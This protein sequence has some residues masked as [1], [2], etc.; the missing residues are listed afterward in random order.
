M[1]HYITQP[2]DY[3]M[4]NNAISITLNAR[5]NPNRIQGSVASGAA[6]LCYIEGVDGLGYDNGHR[7]KTWPLSLSPTYFNS[8]SEK[9]VYVAIPRSVSVGTLAIVVF[10]SEQLDIYGKNAQ[11]VQVGSTDYYYIWLQGVVSSSGVEGTTNR[12]LTGLNFGMKGTDEDLYDNTS[13][14]WYE[15][16]RSGGGLVT[17]LKPILMRAGSYFR[18]LILGDKELTGV[19]TEA[20]SDSYVNSETLVVTPSYLNGKLLSRVNDDTAQGVITFVKGIIA[21]ITSYFRGISNTGTLENNGDVSVT[22]SVTAQ[23]VVTPKVSA[24]LDSDAVVVEDALNSHGISNTGTLENTGNVSVTG[25]VTAQEVVTPRISAPAGSN[26]VVVEDPINATGGNGEDGIGMEVSKSGIVGKLLR[27]GEMLMTRCLQSF[28]FNGGENIDGTGWQ[29]TD[30]DGSGM[31]RLIVDKLVVRAKAIFN[32]LEVRKLVGI[33]GNYV[34]SPAAGIIEEVDYIKLTEVEAQGGIT[35]YEEELLGYEYVRVPW[36]IRLLPLSIQGS[37]LSRLKRVRSTMTEELWAQVSVFRCWLRADDGTTQTIN[38]WREGMLARCQ[39]MD[40]GSGDGTST[41]TFYNDAT[42]YTAAENKYY[43]RKV[44]KI[45]DGQTMPL[46]DG[47]LHHYID[48]SNIP[49]EYNLGSDRPSAGDSIACFGDCMH[50]D[51]SNIVMIETVG[52]DAPAIKELV[53]V[54]YVGDGTIDWSLDGKTKT[55]ISPVAGNRFVSREYVIETEV[56][57]STV[58]EELYNYHYRGNAKEFSLDVIV[59]YSGSLND[60]ELI[61][62]GSTTATRNRYRVCT[63]AGED[64]SSPATWQQRIAQIG[65]GYVCDADGHLYVAGNGGWE[66]RGIYDESKSAYLSGT[67]KQAIIGDVNTAFAESMGYTSGNFTTNMGAFVQSSTQAI[68]SITAHVESLTA[69]NIL[70]TSTD[71]N[72]DGSRGV[73]G[74]DVYYEAGGYA[75]GGAQGGTP[76]TADAK[77]T[78][79]FW[80]TSKPSG[81]S[82]S[83]KWTKEVGSGISA[84]WELVGE[85]EPITFTGGTILDSGET[86]GERHLYY[87]TFQAPDMPELSP[88]QQLTPGNIFRTDT[89]GLTA[90][91][92]VIFNARLT[93]GETAS[94]LSRISETASLV[95]QTAS[96]IDMNVRD[97]LGDVG[98]SITGSDKRIHLTADKTEIDGDVTVGSLETQVANG[99]KTM[100]QGG[101]N[102][103]YDAQG[104]PLMQWGVVQMGT[105]TSPLPSL[106]FYGEENGVWMPTACINASNFFLKGASGTVIVSAWNEEMEMLT[107]VLNMDCNDYMTLMGEIA[108]GT[109][110]TTKHTYY[111]FHS[112]QV[113]GV[114]SDTAHDGKYV[115]REVTAGDSSATIDSLLLNGWYLQ[116]TGVKTSTYNESSY[117]SASGR[118]ESV[119]IYKRRYHTARLIRFVNGV[120]AEQH[121]ITFGKYLFVGSPTSFNAHLIDEFKQGEPYAWVTTEDVTIANFDDWYDQNQYDIDDA[122]GYK[123]SFRTVAGWEDEEEYI[124][125]GNALDTFGDMLE[126]LGVVLS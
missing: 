87:V 123:H 40:I 108:D 36:V 100:I 81:I 79:S 106:I 8:N 126:R 6:I 70:N 13:S 94:V 103:V 5:S 44:R 2:K 122:D 98:I 74:E 37:Y 1:E 64:E 57:G 61:T 96:S 109:D 111:I 24:P 93:E 73:V 27:V 78:L 62:D 9:Y 38:T 99:F 102:G 33:G 77:Y 14:E 22:G 46:D 121:D 112:S 41:T 28:N 101:L 25:S 55:R 12:E 88:S 59:S 34:F 115:S 39:T 48:L 105:M 71:V 124:D 67:Y 3:W 43:W 82:I 16:S 63:A 20:T 52:S 85:S 23:E 120:K 45:G 91:G 51:T 92:G 10:P 107:G 104:R 17:L 89:V 58:S 65:D 53:N 31:S 116:D 60:V 95:H 15:Y 117:N 30:N 114:S 68:S 4:A 118:K 54:G 84:S 26:A 69:P 110:T 113:N 49:G 119:T 18:N 97:D 76:M 125:S 19:A 90:I 66:D 42:H 83:S 29:L 7:F 21:N 86:D 72:D 47:R 56:S 32:E 50:Q 11:S 80:S 75:T 35:E